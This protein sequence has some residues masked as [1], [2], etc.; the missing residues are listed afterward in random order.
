MFEEADARL[1]H[2][3]KWRSQCFCFKMMSE[4]SCDFQKICETTAIMKKYGTQKS[5]RAHCMATLMLYFA[6]LDTFFIH[7][8][9]LCALIMLRVIRYATAVCFWANTERKMTT[10]WKCTDVWCS[11]MTTSSTVLTTFLI[12]YQNTPSVC[13]KKFCF[14][15]YQRTLNVLN[16]EGRNNFLC[17]LLNI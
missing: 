6:H 8:L 1:L 10:V 3:P 16:N 14:T 12:E 11:V 15:G 13:V 2:S 7:L 9:S 5:W 17:D 4:I